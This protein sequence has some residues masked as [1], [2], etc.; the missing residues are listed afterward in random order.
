M[1]APVS[2]LMAGLRFRSREEI[3]MSLLMFLH[4]EDR[5]RVMTDT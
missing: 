2:K 4:D 1:S 3:Y 5:F